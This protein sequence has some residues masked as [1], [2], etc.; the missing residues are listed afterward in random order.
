MNTN[1]QL[2]E[3]VKQAGGEYLALDSMGLWYNEPLIGSTLLEPDL[4]I[5]TVDYLKGR[6]ADKQR[7]FNK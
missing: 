7:D 4:S 6:L 1:Q 5:I 3:I 2:K